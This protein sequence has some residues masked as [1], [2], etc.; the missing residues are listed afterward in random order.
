MTGT[1]TILLTLGVALVGAGAAPEGWASTQDR[2]D[3]DSTHD[4]LHFSHPLIAESPSPD[5][6]VRLDYF[7]RNDAGEDGGSRNTLRIE[8]EYAFA[9]WLSIEVD[10]PYTFLDP[11]GA[12]S[13]DRLD[14]VEVGLKYASFAFEENDLL[15]GG[16]IEL[17]LPTGNDGVGIG[18]NNVLEVEPFVDFGYEL[19]RLQLVG[20][21]SFGVPTNENGEDEADLELAWNLSLQVRLDERVA[22]LLELD[23]EEV[24]GGDKNGESIVNITPGIKIA[25]LHDRNLRIGVGV[26]LP[27]THDKEFHVRT[28]LS[29]FY[30][31]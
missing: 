5:T 14:T 11:E 15:L 27:L 23:G 10:V 30:H 1:R 13:E 17:G 18:S 3:H 12:S 2:H 28:V 24:F 9:R 29:V 21:A 19:D 31:F 20:L 7:F 8:A 26:S 22:A 4:G 25:P 16:G 6:K